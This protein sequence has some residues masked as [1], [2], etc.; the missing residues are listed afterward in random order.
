MWHTGTQKEKHLQQI[1]PGLPAIPSSSDCET[2]QQFAFMMLFS[3]LG[4][5][6]EMYGKGR[7]WREGR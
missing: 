7:H 5:T 1:T 6:I 4:V 3:L 2:Q